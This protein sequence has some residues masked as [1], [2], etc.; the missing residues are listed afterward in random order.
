MDRNGR[1]YLN[2]PDQAP[3]SVYADDPQLSFVEDRILVRGFKT[4]ARVGKTVYRACIGLALA[5][6]SEVSLAP[7]GEGETIGFRDARLERIS[8]QGN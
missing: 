4:Q 5:P 7:N 8:E 2:G 6:T 1:Y 3:C